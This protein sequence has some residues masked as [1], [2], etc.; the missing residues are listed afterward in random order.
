[1]RFALSLMTINDHKC[2][3]RFSITDFRLSYM[4]ASSCCRKLEGLPV[5]FTGKPTPKEKLALATSSFRVN[6]V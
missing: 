5:A 2:H 6:S 4:D 3:V 1:M